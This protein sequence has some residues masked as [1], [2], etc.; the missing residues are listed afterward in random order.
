MQSKISQA[1]LESN[2]RNGK[3]YGHLGGASYAK[4][5]AELKIIKVVEYNKNPKLCKHCQNPIPY[6]KKVNN[7]CNSS[8]SGSYNTSNRDK[9]VIEKTKATWRNK[10][11]S[12]VE[13][14]KA[15]KVKQPKNQIEPN[16]PYSKL[17]RCTCQ[18]CGYKALYRTQQK[19][20]NNCSHLYSHDGRAK[21]WFTFNVF[22][23]PD[24]FDLSLITTHGFRDNKT[25]PNGITRDHKISVN[26][27]IRNGSDPYYIKHPMNCELMF[28]NENNKKKTNSSITYQELIKLVDD[29]DKK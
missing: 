28:F 13:L 9:S 12:L 14:R 16:A 3:L 6:D 8:C 4:K 10:N 18:H 29:Y 22:H 17:F 23:Y 19:Y 20:C 7:F 1:H 24:L 27:A 5:M 2:R 11:K 15:G 21:F 26:D 25:N